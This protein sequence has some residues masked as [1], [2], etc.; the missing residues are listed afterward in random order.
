MEVD[1]KYKKAPTGACGAE[2]LFNVD[3][4]IIFIKR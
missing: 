4:F 1:K 3:D 2:K